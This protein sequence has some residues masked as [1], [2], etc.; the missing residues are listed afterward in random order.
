MY[1]NRI[2]QVSNICSPIPVP[3]ALV[4]AW[5]Y[6][7]LH[8]CTH[9]V[10]NN[11]CNVNRW[12]RDIQLRSLS[13]VSGGPDRRVFSARYRGCRLTVGEWDHSFTW[14]F[15]SCNLTSPP[16]TRWFAECFIRIVRVWVGLPIP[17]SM[18]HWGWFTLPRIFY[19][20]VEILKFS[21]KLRFPWYRPS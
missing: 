6:Q 8:I 20:F 14:V 21:L 7:C 16:F 11:T 18:S 10:S 19:L 4:P 12:C 1:L 15:G 5:S 17:K 13:I 2:D 9:L 3:K